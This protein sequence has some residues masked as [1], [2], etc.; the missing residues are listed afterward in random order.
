[1]YAFIFGTDIK[2][3]DNIFIDYNKFEITP[4]IN[5]ISDHDAQLL[6]IYDINTLFFDKKFCWMRKI[7]RNLLT[8]FAFD[9]SFETWYHIISGKE[10]DQTFNIFLNII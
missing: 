1:M 2:N 9:L 6:Q 8:S 5:G 4:F 10:V 7:N 3:I